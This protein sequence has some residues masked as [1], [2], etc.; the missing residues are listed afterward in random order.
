MSKKAKKVKRLSFDIDIQTYQRIQKLKG[1]RH[2][3]R[4]DTKAFL[5]AIARG[6]AV[7][8]R[9]VLEGVFDDDLCKEDLEAKVI[10]IM[11]DVV[12]ENIAA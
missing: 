9:Q 1:N 12:H 10:S 3:W 8:E 6:V 2:E 7:M 4:H 11:D 5:A